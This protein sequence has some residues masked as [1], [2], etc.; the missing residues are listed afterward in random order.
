MNRKVPMLGLITLI[1][2]AVAGCG[3]GGEGSVASSIPDH[4]I[5]TRTQGSTTPVAPPTLAAGTNVQLYATGSYNDGSTQDITPRVAWSSNSASATVSQGLVHGVSVGTTTI[6]AVLSA[7]AGSTTATVTAATLQSI[8]ISPTTMAAW[9]LGQKQQFTATG[10]YSDNSQQDVTSIV[11][12][13]ASKHTVATVSNAAGSQG[14]ATSLSQ[15]QVVVTAAATGVPTATTSTLTVGPAALVSIAVTPANSSIP[16]GTTQTFTATGTYSD[17]STADLTSSVAYTATPSPSGAATFTG[18]SGPNVAKATTVGI[19]TVKA[20]SGSINGTTQLTVTAPVLT[21]IAVTPTRVS[22]HQGATQP[23]TATG[24]Y[25]DATT[26]D[27]T[28]TV[29]WSAGNGSVATI[30]TSG[31]TAGLATGVAAGTVAVVASFKPATGPA[32]TSTAT[33]GDGNLTVIGLTAINLN[34]TNPSLP[35]G[36]A[37]PANPFGATNKTAQFTATAH[38]ADNTTADVT[39]TATWT[40]SDPTVATINN[41]GS[42]GLATLVRAGPTTITATYRSVPGTT[43]LTVLPAVL[44]SITVAPNGV[45]LGLNGRQQFTATGSYSDGTSADITNTAT[46][47]SF[48]PHVVTVATSGSTRGMATVVAATNVAVA[49]T[50]SSGNVQPFGSTNTAFVSALSSLPVVCPTPTI[51]MKLLVV[52]NPGANLGAGY[53]DFPAIQQILNYVGTPYD[54]VDAMSATPTLS[55]GACHGFYQG[56]IYAFGNDIYT[57]PSLNAALTSYEQTFKV[58]R[59]NWYINPTPDFGLNFSPSQVPATGTDSG[60]FTAA[61]APIF[62]YANPNTPVAISNASI[63][64]TTPTTPSGGGT[65]TP[66]LVDPAGNTLSAITNFSDGRQYL[67][68][69]FDSNAFLMHNLRLAYGLLNWVTQG[70]FLGDYHVYASAQVDDF[71]INDAEWVPGTPCTNPVTHDRNPPDLATLPNFRLTSADMAPLVAWQNAMQADPLLSNFKLT[72]AF[73]GVGTVGNPAWTG[74]SLPGITNTAAVSPTNPNGVVDDLVYNLSTYQQPFHW[75]THTFDHPNSLNPL[76]KSDPLG[77]PDNPQIDSIDLEILTNLYV[78]GDPNGLQLDPD[79]SDTTPPAGATGGVNPLTFT[80]FNPGNLVSPGVTGLNDPLVPTYLFQDGIRYVVS[81]TSVI[82]QPN[83][84]PNPSPNVGIVNSFAPGI[85]EVPRYPNDIF[86]NA[87]NWADDQAE[88]HCIYGPTP[89]PAQPPFDAYVAKDILNFVSDSF[90]VN[91]LKGDMNP[92]MFHQPN[93][94]F[95]DNA[96]TLGLT[97]SHVSSLLTDTY[98]QTFAKYKSLYNLPV[99]SPTLDQTAALMQ[100]RNSYNLSG[101][102][103]SMIGVGSATPQIQLTMPATSTSPATAVIPVTGLTST[104]SELYGGQNISHIDMTPGQTITFPLQ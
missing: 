97:G 59:L 80:D 20:T 102:T 94:H 6:S 101:V 30:S 83:N 4:I 98:D 16:N 22:A 40:S 18:N 54:V 25:S 44:E 89:G 55:D 72:L 37:N 34:P 2:L 71:F 7:K 14:L 85:Y 12:W 65:V 23:F 90:V 28:A 81:D 31:A 82:G 66:L 53:A 91:L 77:D 64:L 41:T 26:K 75:I 38:F 36:D 13:D 33:G 42:K 60:T 86:Y 49:I 50:A 11:T 100:N 45:S 104:G 39:A 24:T 56:I 47:T 84:G 92:E 67:S 74:L 9:S 27:V 62:F 52:N 96:A 70:V 29:A 78:A 8:A 95:A 79:P 35:L 57:N 1:S 32:I 68:Q 5:L 15:G 103:A 46:W 87:A 51:D 99:L 43:L 76:H 48:N 3:G 17:N 88:F 63:F 58:R 19:V 73:N 21:S 93:L 61:A 69:M 10:T